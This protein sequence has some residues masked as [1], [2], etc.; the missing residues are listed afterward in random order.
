[1]PPP[2]DD[3][4]EALLARAAEDIALVRT[5]LDVPEITDAIV[6][7]HSQQAAEKLLK[8]VLA[9][10]RIVYP[11]THDLERLMELVEDVA[12]AGPPDRE[13]VVALTPWAVEF[14]YGDV[15][16]DELDR[17][18]TLTLVEGLA[19]WVSDYFD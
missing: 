10:R 1:L 7:F 19:G 17:R 16:E 2:E 9:R 13:S 15:P 18:S 3:I 4:S 6:G 8:A 11:Y 14:R 5:S 12:G